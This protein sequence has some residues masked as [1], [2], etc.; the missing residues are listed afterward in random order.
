MYDSNVS[1]ITLN[2]KKEE[3]FQFAMVINI[4]HASI[5]LQDH[6]C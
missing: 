1:N 4:M 3:F 5:V 6:L 2:T